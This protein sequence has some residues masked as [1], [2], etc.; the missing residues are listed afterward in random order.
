[1]QHVHAD[2]DGVPRHVHQAQG[3]VA[4]GE[5]LK[6]RDVGLLGEC[7]G[8]IRDGAGHRVPHDHNQLGVSGH[9]E[10]ASGSLLSD[11]VAGRLLER[12]LALQGP[13]HQ[14]PVWAEE[15]HHQIGLRG[16]RPQAQL[17]QPFHPGT[18]CIPLLASVPFKALTW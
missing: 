8:V 12:D 10:D 1:M 9:V 14:A 13:G 7:L 2:A 5:A 17:R 3:A 18:C 11:E 16:A 15:T 4:E 6:G